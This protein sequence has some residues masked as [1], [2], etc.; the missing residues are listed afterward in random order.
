MRSSSYYIAIYVIYDVYISKSSVTL[1]FV[2]DMRG[3]FQI[4][5]PHGVAAQRWL[6]AALSTLRCH[7]VVR[8]SVAG[9]N[10][11]SATCQ[12]RAIPN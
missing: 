3:A 5:F 10:A 6:H 2:N 1:E 9:E 8:Q 12:A 11:S 7:G 4:Q